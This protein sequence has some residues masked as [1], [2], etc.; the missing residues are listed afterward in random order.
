MILVSFYSKKNF[1]PNRIRSNSI[2]S[3]DAILKIKE[4]RCCVLS[5][6]SCIFCRPKN[7]HG[8]AGKCSITVTRVIES[9]Q[10]YYFP[11]KA[12][13]EMALS[14]S[15]GYGLGTILDG[16]K[17]AK[18]LMSWKGLTIHTS[19]LYWVTAMKGYIECTILWVEFYGNTVVYVTIYQPVKPLWLL[20][21]HVFY[22]CC[23]WVFFFTN[24]VLYSYRF[25]DWTVTHMCYFEIIAFR[26]VTIELCTNSLITWVNT[27]II[28]ASFYTCRN[29]KSCNSMYYLGNPMNA[30]NNLGV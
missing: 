28:A 2:L 18:K 16:M 4:R 1:L 29:L 3:I 8:I 12:G 9:V 17:F 26:Q 25:Y 11:I 6:P 20:L 5:R 13:G 30:R 7:T 27:V 23:M 14:Q 22:I 10:L 21:T 15:R 24:V 19:W